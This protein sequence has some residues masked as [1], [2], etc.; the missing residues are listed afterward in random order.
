MIPLSHDHAVP[1]PEQASLVDDISPFQSIDMIPVGTATSVTWSL[2]P[3]VR[4]GPTRAWTISVQVALP[5]A[6]NMPLL[7]TL[8]AEGSVG[9]RYAYDGIGRRVNATSGGSWTVSINGGG[10]D[11]LFEKTNAGDVSKYVYANGMR[12]AKIN[13]DGSIHY[14]LGDHQGSTRKVL[15]ASRN[16]VFSAEY[17]PFG[18]PYNVTGS[19]TYRYTM[20]KHDDPTGLVYLRARM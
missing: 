11:P 18:K 8:V 10:M 3:S 6:G 19:E 20:K 12:I 4:D 15:D 5:N 13:P 16:V 17:E 7:M 1:L 9:T 2:A 14:Y